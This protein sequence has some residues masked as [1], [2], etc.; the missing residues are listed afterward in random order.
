MECR[1]VAPSV[2]FNNRSSVFVQN[3]ATSGVFIDGNSPRNFITGPGFRQLDL[4]FFRDIKFRE[5]LNAQ[6]RV[7]ST[8]LF[9]HPNLGQPAA[10]VGGSGFGTI[11]TA[12]AMRQLQF[13]IRL[14]F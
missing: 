12:N 6:F 10:T 7:E 9:N 11:S 5:R 13:G 1:W 2:G 3:Q 8:N 14:T 4:A